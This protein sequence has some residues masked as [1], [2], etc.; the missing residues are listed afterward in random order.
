MGT[1][2]RRR[3]FGVVGVAVMMAAIAPE[4]G[5]LRAGPVRAGETREASVAH[6]VLPT[7]SPTFRRRARRGARWA[8]ASRR[9]A[10]RIVRRR[11]RRKSVAYRW[12]GR[13]NVSRASGVTLKRA[14]DVTV[15]TPAAQTETGQAERC[16][17]ATGVGWY[18]NAAGVETATMIMKQRWC[19]NGRRVTDWNEPFYDSSVTFFARAYGVKWEN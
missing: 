15:R 13:S 19:W 2:G 10:R 16:G 4:I 3:R 11:K 9:Q 8:G 5:A 18:G 1:A 12:H 14:T 7:T 6:H 17:T